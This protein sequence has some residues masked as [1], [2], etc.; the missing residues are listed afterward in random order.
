MIIDRDR[1]NLLRVFLTNHVIIE[2]FPD[3]G[4]LDETE[5]GLRGTFSWSGSRSRFLNFTINDR[6]TN[7]DASITNINPWARDNLADFG[8]RFSAERAKGDAR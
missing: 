1:E 3:I 6:L 8:L 4:R 5:S 2:H 7:V